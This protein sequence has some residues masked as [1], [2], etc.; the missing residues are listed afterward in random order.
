MTKSN[1]S[2]ACATL[3]LLTAVARPAWA[4][5]AGENRQATYA[6]PID[7]PYRFQAPYLPFKEPRVP[8]REAADPTMVFFKGEYWLFAS[9]SLGYWRSPDLQH[10]RFVKAEGYAVDKFAPTAVAIDGKLYMAVSEGARQIWV[11][12]DPGSGRWRVAADIPQGYQ[13]PCLFLDDDGR[14]YMY[15][16]LSPNGPLNVAEL[17]RGTFLPIRKDAIPQ[18]RDK[19]HRGWEVPG[20]HNERV[21]AFSFIE[22][23]WMTKHA[24]RYYLEYSAPGTEFKAYANGVATAATAM[25]PF[26]FQPYSPFAAKPTGFITGAGHGSTFEGPGGQW[27]H[28]GTMTISM[29]HIFERRLGL[30]PTRFTASG[31]MVTDTYLGDYPH[32]FGGSRGLTGW[33]LLSRGKPV[34]ASSA[35]PGFAPEKAVDEDVRSWWS[36]ATGNPGEWFQVDL[37]AGRTIEALQVN[38]ADQDAAAIGASDDGYRY[39]VEASRDGKDWRPIVPA[40]ATG[41]DAPHDYRV[42]PRPVTARFV[43]IRN[44]H[45]PNGAKFSLYDLRVFGN[46]A[47]PLPGQVTHMEATRDSADPRH[48]RITWQPVRGADFYIV[49]LGIR[50]DLMIQNY[51]V[52]DGATLDLRSLNADTPYVFTVDAVNERGIAKNR[53]PAESIR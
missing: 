18:V 2:R 16:G 21:N 40:T 1:I 36:A 32:Y 31:E 35:L 25:G 26:T 46:A 48:A 39:E 49:R 22:G 8:F 34:T 5:D 37:G 20:D 7:L 45:S 15:D 19:A 53:L 3:A 47:M 6:N 14:L 17:D 29:R 23:S 51:Q 28:I 38:F 33:M 44:L 41:R 24:G 9:H 52:Y 10:W 11:T 42:L 12:D 30:F 4:T 50:P 43:R 13:D 27:W